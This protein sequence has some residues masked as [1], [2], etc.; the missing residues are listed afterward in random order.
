MKVSGPTFILLLSAV[1]SPAG[2]TVSNLTMTVNPAAV[3]NGETITVTANYCSSAVGETDYFM[4]A[5]ESSGTSVITC[6]SLYQ[7][8]LVDVNGVGVDET[9][10][11]PVT[12]YCQSGYPVTNN[13]ALGTGACGAAGNA[14]SVTFVV[15]MPATIQSGSDY[16]LVLS[17]ANNYN[18]CVI[19]TVPDA[20]AIYPFTVTPPV[21]GP[22]SL[23]VSGENDFL[24]G[25]LIFFRVDYILNSQTGNIITDTLPPWVTL[26]QAG[27]SPYT[28]SVNTFTWDLPNASPE[29]QGTVYVLARVNANTPLGTSL[30]SSVTYTSSSGIN[31][32]SIAV[33]NTMGTPF[34]L[35]KSE[36]PAG[37]LNAGQ[38]LTYTLAYQYDDIGL[39]FADSYDYDTPGSSTVTG[40]DGTPYSS[41]VGGWSVVTGVAGENY[42]TATSAA[43]FTKIL[44]SNPAG[45]TYCPFGGTGTVTDYFVQGDMEVGINNGSN[46]DG[47]DAFMVIYDSCSGEKYSW[48]YRPTRTR[49]M[50]LSR[51]PWEPVT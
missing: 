32:S 22:V 21:A 3:V 34:T 15:T 37:P 31:N 33:T 27:P 23:S 50:F 12:A 41:A 30:V 14:N 29:I 26:V 38:T 1:I 35:A 8:F 51:R 24:P 46:P 5:L 28:Q 17:T 42:L 39:Q 36:A 10:P 7:Q 9:A 2:A 13:N 49:T 11:C 19:P 40:Y 44:R 25:D 43:D 45:V 4:L 18:S 48:G 6:P 47:A 20:T 16:N